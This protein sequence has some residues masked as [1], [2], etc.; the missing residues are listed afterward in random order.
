MELGALCC[1]DRS[2]R[3]RQWSHSTVRINT[4]SS[5][6][7]HHDFNISLIAWRKAT[8]VVTLEKHCWLNKEILGI[9]TDQLNPGFSIFRLEKEFQKLRSRTTNVCLL[10]ANFLKTMCIRRT[11]HMLAF[12]LS[13][14]KHFCCESPQACFIALFLDPKSLWKPWPF[15]SH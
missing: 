11:Y 12:L 7:T 2:G 5:K 4:L 8:V 3:G 14:A 6:I 1:T 13:S 10:F 15:L 9:L